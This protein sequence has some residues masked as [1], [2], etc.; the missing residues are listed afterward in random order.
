[1]VQW[2]K[3]PVKT[4]QTLL[5]LAEEGGRDVSSIRQGG[6]AVDSTAFRNAVNEML[7]QH[8]QP[9]QP[10][11][12]NWQQQQQHAQL[13]E[14]VLTEYQAFSQRHPDAKVHED[15]IAAVMRDRNVSHEQAYYMVRAFAGEARLDWNQP[16]APQLQA[17]ADRN[18][19]N[20]DPSGG[21]ND[22]GLPNLNGGRS[23]EDVVGVNTRTNQASVDESYDSIA[24]RVMQAH[25]LRVQ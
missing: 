25:G 22:R 15:A 16:L 8:L 6:G 20:I 18:G 24:R 12:A 14:E 10:L 19:G 13:N 2:K 17:R 21:G 5:T 1:M 9:F 4:I 11:I 7:V 23:G 3:D